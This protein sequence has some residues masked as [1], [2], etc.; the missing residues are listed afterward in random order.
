[1]TDT[2]KIEIKHRW[3]SGVVLFAADISAKIGERLRLKAA[4]EI[5]AGSGADLSGADLRGADLSGADLSGADL[6]GADLS[7]ADL[8]GADLSG[9]DLRDADLR[10]AKG[11]VRERAV[12]LLM[13][14]DQ[15]GPIRAYKVV[16]ESGHGH[17]HGGIRYDM[18]HTYEEL[19]ASTDVNEECGSGLHV[20]TLDWC[21]R[22]WRPGFRILVVE[23]TAAD[24][25]CIPTSTDGKFRL[26]RLTVV[27]EKDIVALGLVEPPRP[28]AA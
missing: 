27:G 19:R 4:L 6:R 24:I 22:E 25:A 21:I 17:I 16:N 10:D 3:G 26:R 8:R 13:L 2:V 12:P 28:E 23:F 14:L 18:G 1:M 5:A 7:G 9:A 11:I 15:P 20:A